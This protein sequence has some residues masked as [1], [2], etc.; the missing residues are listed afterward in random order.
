MVSR[1]SFAVVFVVLLLYQELQFIKAQS[2]IRAGYWYSGTGFPVSDINSSLFT[3]LICAFAEVN[4]STYELSITPDD[5]KS[6]SSFTNTVKKKNLSISTLLSIGGSAANSTVFKLMASNVSSRKP[7]IESSIRIAR[8]YGFEGL[9]L[10]WVSANTSSEMR[11]MGNLFEEWRKSAKSEVAENSSSS[12]LILTASVKFRPSMDFTSYPVESIRSNLNWV[13]VLPYDN[14]TFPR[15]NSTASHA[16]LFDPSST[17]NIDDGIKEWIG[18]GIAANKVVLGLPFYGYAWTLKNPNDS[19]SITFTGPAITSGGDM[20][21]KDIKAYIKR[22]GASVK[23][24]STYEVN[25]CTVGSTWIGFDDV[26]V[27]TIKV[28]YAREKNLLGYAVWQVADDDNWVLSAAAAGKVL[29][30]LI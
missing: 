29:K 20:S 19:A 28:A 17:V 26:Q 7:F 12:E 27:V 21:Y 9:D 15:R 13:H 22:N 16:A 14:T 4:P 18:S 1:F 11:N 24:N 25:Y 3:H 5:E 10:A 6:F 30:R 8:L 2:W 23:Y